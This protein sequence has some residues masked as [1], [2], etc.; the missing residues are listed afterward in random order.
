MLDQYVNEVQEH[1]NDSQGQFFKIPTLKNYINRSR[2]RICASSGCLRFIPPGV[3]TIANQEVYPF[4][5]WKSLAQGACPQA[6]SILACR[7][8]AVSL[9]GQWTQAPNGGWTITKGSWKPM[10]RRVVWSDF[11]A[12]FRIYGGTF[13][14]TFSEPGWWAQYG[15]GAV[16]SLYLAP[17]PTISQPMEVDL[18]L[19]PKPLATDGDVE[20][21][22]YPWTDAV[23]YFAAMLALIQQQR[24]QDARQLAEM[25][26]AELPMCAAVVCPT[27]LQ[28]P[29]G[30]TLRSA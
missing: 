11:Q 14:G 18:T 4:A 20:P 15:E 28:N 8:L 7:S 12:R 1:L 19:V 23:S 27:M 30:A 5:M 22:P 3:S 21:I 29:Y 26:N 6:E 25:F 17:I 13:M 9:G 16:A 24:G 2:R 10:W